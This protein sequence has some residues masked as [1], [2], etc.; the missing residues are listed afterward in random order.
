MSRILSTALI[1]AA[2]CLALPAAAQTAPDFSAAVSNPDRSREDVKLDA[3]RKPA[4][5]LA[6]LGLKPGDDAAD[7]MAGAGYYT[8]ILAHAVGPDG[9][10]TAYEPSQFYDSQ[11]LVR[12]TFSA[13]AA[14]HPNVKLT[15]YSFDKF[16]A[17]A[18]SIDFTLLHLVYHDLYWESTEYRVPHTDPAAFL[19]ALYAATRPGG[20]VGVIDHVGPAGDTRTTVDKLHRM[21]PATIKADFAAAGFVLEAESPLLHMPADDLSKNVFDP[22]I[23][24]K[25]DRVVYR[26]RKPV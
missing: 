24:G 5:V 21:D 23:R 10:V 20:I 9:T 6:F 1:G 13:M 17:P 19:K 7:I 25:T 4:E 3:S 15:P 2:F 26:F 14:R 16:A 8:E 22:A 12:S 18:N 11:P